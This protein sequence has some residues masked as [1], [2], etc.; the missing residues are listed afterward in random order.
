MTV[1]LYQQEM[2]KR[3]IVIPKATGCPRRPVTMIVTAPAPERP[4]RSRKASDRTHWQEWADLYLA[5]LT[6]SEVARRFNVNFQSVQYALT[7]LNVP[8]RRKGYGHTHNRMMQELDALRNENRL[9]R[10]K[11]VGLRRKYQEAA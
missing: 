5:G 2:A 4:K 11:L 8:R 6:L 9:L 7:K 3:N 1:S 10:M